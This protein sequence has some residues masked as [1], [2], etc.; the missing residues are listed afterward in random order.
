MYTIGLIGSLLWVSGGLGIFIALILLLRKKNTAYYLFS[1]GLLIKSFGAIM[2]ALMMTKFIF[3]VPNL[4][5]TPQPLQY[6]I[7]PA[8]YYFVLLSLKPHHR[9]KWWEA[10][11]LLPFILHLGEMMPFYLSGTEHKLTLIEEAYRNSS[12]IVFGRYGLTLDYFQHL[13]LKAFLTF[14]YSV[15]ALGHLWTKY[16]GAMRP[17]QKQNHSLYKW[18]A[19]EL[20]MQA[21]LQIVFMT[22]AYWNTTSPSLDIMVIAALSLNVVISF[23]YIILN[24][25]LLE[26]TKPYTFALLQLPN[27][28][29]T[30]N[31]NPNTP[32]QN[33]SQGNQEGEIMDGRIRS[34]DFDRIE[35][36]FQ[37]NKP[38]IRED[39]S[40]ESLSASLKMPVR[41]ISDAIRN[42]T[43]MHFSD[44]VNSY[45][46][47]Y[48]EEN[49]R[50][51]ND[52]KKYTIDAIAAEIGFSSRISF[53]QATKRHR[54][55]SPT[56]LI[57]NLIAD[58]GLN[59]AS[60]LNYAPQPT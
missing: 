57:N 40:R 29:Q 51:R 59:P 14:S 21:I 11:H 2:L 36:L 42:A 6:L 49:M 41:R 54:N 1:A 52:W 37:S 35:N 10:I 33:N 18:L 23:S 60:P 58:P 32:N 47:L 16:Y 8:Y 45:R 5:L 39:F 27:E 25:Y 48:L 26:G 50:T 38:Y 46:I 34:T 13:F 22:K 56:E 7:G 28:Q 44:Y 24:P 55:Q 31:G 12:T 53:Y 43:G 15:I 9:F 20:S 4:F 30:P 3:H 19:L 17:Y